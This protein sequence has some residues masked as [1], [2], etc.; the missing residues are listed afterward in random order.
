MTTIKASIG[1]FVPAIQSLMYS[2]N[3]FR[4]QL[5]G[6]HDQDPATVGRRIVNLVRNFFG[7]KLNII[8][9]YRVGDEYV[10]AVT[11]NRWSNDS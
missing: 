5:S 1:D 8:Y 10:F 11:V 6:I 9:Q 4:L 2:T 7:S 3:M